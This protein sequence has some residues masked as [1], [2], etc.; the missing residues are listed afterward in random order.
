MDIYIYNKEKEK[1]VPG[2]AKGGVQRPLTEQQQSATVGK[3]G[4]CSKER[5]GK[6]REAGLSVRKVNKLIMS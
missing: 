2:R 4:Q 6:T 5:A 1:G 3:R